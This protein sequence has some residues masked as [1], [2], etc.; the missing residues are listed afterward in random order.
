MGAHSFQTLGVV[1][2]L[3]APGGVVDGVDGVEAAHEDQQDCDVGEV[4][5]TLLGEGEHDLQ[6]VNIGQLLHMFAE[7]GWATSHILLQ[8]ATLLIQTVSFCRRRGN[9]TSRP[10][11][12]A[13]LRPPASARSAAEPAAMGYSPP[14]PYPKTNCGTRNM[15]QATHGPQ[16][17]IRAFFVELLC[18]QVGTCHPK[19]VIALKLRNSSSRIMD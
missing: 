6:E 17:S 10:R 1:G 18:T 4:T 7:R 11:L 15:H 8:M 13:D 19:R 16:S 9:F 14:T 2:G 12:A 5:E 3:L